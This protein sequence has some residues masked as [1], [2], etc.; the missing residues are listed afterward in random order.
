MIPSKPKLKIAI[1]YGPLLHYRLALFNA[2]CDRYNL[3]VFTTEFAGDDSGLRFAV[4]V[5]PARR[6]GPFRFQPGLRQKLRQGQFD[7]CISFLDVAHID[8]LLAIFLPVS[9]RTFSWGAWLTG[10]R[11]ANFLRVAA[12]K[13]CEANL[14]YCYQKMQEIA[15]CGAPVGSLYVAH[16]TVAVPKPMPAVSADQRDLI[17]FV[18]SFDAR[19]GLDRLLRVFAE[20]IPRLPERVRLML[21]GDGPERSRLQALAKDLRLGERL[22]M[23]GRVNDPDKLGAYYTRAL[24]S[25]SLNQA[26][27]S[28]LQ[29]MG[30]GVP[31]LTVCGS[32]SPGYETLNIT[33]GVNGF[34]VDD[35]DT[36]IAEVFQAL[37]CDPA[38]ASRMGA[39]AREH[40]LRYATIENYAQGFFDAIE[41]T[42]KA[43]IWQGADFE[44]TVVDHEKHY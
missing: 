24:V 27:L 43:L 40:Y 36:A 41:G 31:F 19:K 42:R 33:D 25:V 18:G 35:S 11:I 2:I 21:V 7:V 8:T 16:N 20:T 34:V 13:R 28:V 38:L 3:T 5:I 12:M 10:S 30:F 26:G 9:P 6:L 37:A 39:S 17:L 4:E 1:I 44:E 23:P 22:M 15:A 32:L 29:S 14:F